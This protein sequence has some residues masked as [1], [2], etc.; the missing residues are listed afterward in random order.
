MSEVIMSTK[1]LNKIYDSE[2]EK[3][4]ALNNVNLDLYEGDFTVIMGSSGS[5]KST[6]LYSISGMDTISGGTIMFGNEAISD[7]NEEELCN[8]RRKN[9]GFVFQGINLIQNI[10]LYENVIVS[11]H[12]ADE[13]DK[14]LIGERAKK[15]LELV[16]LSEQMER[17]PSQVSGGQQQRAAIARALVNAPK[18]LFADEPTGALNSTSGTAILNLLTYLNIKGQTIIMVTHDV[19]AAARANR[20]IFIIDGQIYDDLYLGPYRR[21]DKEDREDYIY[22]HLTRMGW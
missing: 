17:L 1:N 9:T 10:S 21:H 7:Y 22:S 15:L 11:G 8:F 4:F 12:I 19:K 20:L 5:G 6:L 13:E 2:G 14:D 16:G 18:I 3:F